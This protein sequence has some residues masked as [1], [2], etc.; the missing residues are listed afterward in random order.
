MRLESKKIQKA[1]ALLVLLLFFL[2]ACSN[3]VCNST[4]TEKVD[5]SD[6]SE[7]ADNNGAADIGVTYESSAPGSYVI[8]GYDAVYLEYHCPSDNGAD[9]DWLYFVSPDFFGQEFEGLEIEGQASWTD[10]AYAVIEINFTEKSELD[11]GG[12]VTGPGHS[13]EVDTNSGALL[14][15]SSTPYLTDEPMSLTD[16]RIIQIGQ[17]VAKIMRDAEAYAQ[18]PEEE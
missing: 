7:T 13:F 1:T 11:D 16:E 18:M 6:I 4:H 8:K 3:A 14:A 10:K 2:S 12:T 5:E 15:H 9:D 17:Q